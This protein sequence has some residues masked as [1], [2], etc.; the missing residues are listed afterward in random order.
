VPDQEVAE[1]QNAR[2]SI[3][4][5]GYDRDEVDR[6][7]SR[8]NQMLAELQITAAPESAIKYALEKVSRDTRSTV[9]EAQREAED[10]TRDSRAKAH[11]RLEEAAKE[12]EQLREAAEREAR[13]L[14]EAAARETH[15]TRAAAETRIRELEAE[16]QAMAE[17]RDRAVKEL[18]ELARSVAELVNAQGRDGSASPEPAKADVAG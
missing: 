13:K 9:E 14:R 1:V 2:F 7:M 4:L 6:Y 17:Q 11:D 5:R 15:G 8:V 18:E 10:I 3:A 12:A 16:V